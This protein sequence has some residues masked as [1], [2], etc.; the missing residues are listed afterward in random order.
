LTHVGTVSSA[1][2]EDTADNQ[3]AVDSQV[4]Y[5]DDGSVYCKQDT[6]PDE[7]EYAIGDDEAS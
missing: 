6:G 3:E 4:Y 5:Q 1:L 7:A 2:E